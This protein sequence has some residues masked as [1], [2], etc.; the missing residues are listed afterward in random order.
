MAVEKGIAAIRNR[1]DPGVAQAGR[2]E[3]TLAVAAPA[4]QVRGAAYGSAWT[5]S[6]PASRNFATAQSTARSRA[7]EPV[8]RPPIVSVSCLRSS[9]IGVGASA[10][11]MSTE[12]ALST[13]A[14]ER[15]TARR[16]ARTSRPRVFFINAILSGR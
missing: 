3:T 16:P 9:T 1:S 2:G 13:S 6:R 5:F 14:K 8:G 12:P 4:S 15:A 7:A 11:R 10:R